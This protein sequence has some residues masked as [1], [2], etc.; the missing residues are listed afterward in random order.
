MLVGSPGLRG[1]QQ[2]H[3]SCTGAPVSLPSDGD[4]TP[5]S[6]LRPESEAVAQ[7]TVVL[8]KHQPPLYFFSSV[9]LVISVI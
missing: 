9:I 3:A 7:G 4:G 5:A 2:V 1:A 8:P 6:Q